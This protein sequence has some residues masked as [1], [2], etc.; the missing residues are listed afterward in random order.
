MT[1]SNWINMTKTICWK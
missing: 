1:N